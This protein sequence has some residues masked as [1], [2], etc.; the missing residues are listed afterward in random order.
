M[1]LI[2][3]GQ[4]FLVIELLSIGSD[5][6]QGNRLNWSNELYA[7]EFN[8]LRDCNLYCEET[9]GPNPPRVWGG[10]TDMEALKC[11][12]QPKREVLQVFI[13]YRS[14]TSNNVYKM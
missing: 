10:K 1:E 5:F 2:L 6:S 7:G 12:N 13:A 9:C 4:R 11:N 14:L 8:H 3:N